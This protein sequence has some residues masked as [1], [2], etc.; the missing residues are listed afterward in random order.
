MENSKRP[1]VLRA[2][3]SGCA[4]IAISFIAFAVSGCQ[5]TDPKNP[6]MTLESNPNAPKDVIQK[7]YGT[8]QWNYVKNLKYDAFVVLRGYV[9]DNYSIPNPRITKSFPDTTRDA[10]ARE[11]AK[12]IRLTPVT[13][14]GRLRASAEIYVYFYETAL[15]PRQALVIAKQQ[16]SIGPTASV[17]GDLYLI[18]VTY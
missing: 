11:F 10:L 3:F 16:S 4:A 18:T 12:D 8:Q 14:A 9:S 1:F 15:N 17:G 6:P 7:F 2:V 13:V 5:S